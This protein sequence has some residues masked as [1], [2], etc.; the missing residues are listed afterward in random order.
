MTD[1]DLAAVAADGFDNALL[2]QVY[3]RFCTGVTI[4][5]ALDG[6][7]PVGFTAQTFTPLSLDPPLILFCP[8]KTSSSWPR[9]KEAGKFCVN[10]LS[11]EQEALC[12]AFAASGAD[13]FRGV[14]WKPAPGTGMPLLDEVLAYA[15]GDIEAEHDGGDHVIAVG[16]VT[17]LEVFER[18]A[19]PLLFYRSGFGRF[20]S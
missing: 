16:R 5:T 7:D 6:D 9:I 12:R 3:G 4:I 19:G 11:D 15:E 13:K 20:E 14:G 17:G 10:I 2:K 8:Q 18:A 1:S